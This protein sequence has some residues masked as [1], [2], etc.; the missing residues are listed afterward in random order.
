VRLVLAALMVC[1]GIAHVPGFLAS[2]RLAVLQGIPYRTVLFAGRVDVGDRG[3][4]VVGVAWLVLGAAFVMVSGAALFAQPWWLPSAFVVTLASLALCAAELPASRV[5][6]GV[7]LA[8]LAVL[9][10]AAASRGSLPPIRP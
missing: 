8:M 9:A 4:R 1:H 7:N 6:V 5:G 10:L 3:M 2:W